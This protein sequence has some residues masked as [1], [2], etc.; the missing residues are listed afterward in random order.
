M[1]KTARAAVLDGA[2]LE[3]LRR[4]VHGDGAAAALKDGVLTVR[5]PEPEGRRGGEYVIAVAS[6]E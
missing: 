3:R 5:L 1:K 4:P 2:Q 6:D